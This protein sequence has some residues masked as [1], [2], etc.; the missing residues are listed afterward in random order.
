M[1]TKDSVVEGILY[2][3]WVIALDES[4]LEK[5]KFTTLKMYQRG[6]LAS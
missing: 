6:R 4:I 3:A 1:A 5:T 2:N